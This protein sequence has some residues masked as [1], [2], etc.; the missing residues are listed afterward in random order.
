M[1]AH[2]EIHNLNAQI[3]FITHPSD[4]KQINKQ[5]TSLISAHLW[6]LENKKHEE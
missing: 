2:C 3:V 1:K 5:R 6:R 4:T